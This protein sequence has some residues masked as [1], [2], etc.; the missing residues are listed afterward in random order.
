MS[1]ECLK[2]Y[3]GRLKDLPP[4][5]KALAPPPPEAPPTVPLPPGVYWHAQIGKYCVQL[6]RAGQP[7]HGPYS[8]DLNALHEWRCA[9]EAELDAQGVPATRVQAKKTPASRQS[10]TPGVT[11]NERMQR[12]VGKCVD[13][14]ASAEAGA[15]RYRRT[16]YSTDEAACVAALAALRAQ[17]H[18]AFETEVAKRQA[19]DPRLAGLD[20]APAFADAQR[21]T[22]YCRVDAQT[23]YVP[24]RVVAGAK[25]YERA[26]AECHQLAIP[27]T[28]GGLPTHCKQHGG[29]RRCPGPVG[30]TECP[31]GI[32]VDLGERD[33]YDGR[34]A[35]CFCAALPNDPRAA[36][37][38]SSVH[39]K[40]RKVTDELKKCFPEY[41]WV[42]DKTFAHR[43]FVVGTRHRPDARF[44]HHDRV[45]IVEVDE[46]SHRSYLCSKEREREASF[47]VQNRGKTVVMIRFNPD[48]YTDY[49]GKRIPSCFT[50]A[51]KDNQIVHVP[52]KQKA[53]WKRRLAELVRTIETLADPDF[54]LPPKQEDRPLLI[55][56]LF[57]DNVNATPEDERVAA[58]LAGRKAIGKRQRERDEP[59]KPAKPIQRKS[60]KPVQR[61]VFDDS[62]DSD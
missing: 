22:V 5:G 9:K 14:L 1:K 36:A 46:H 6:N 61:P 29:G 33:R 56:E 27:N 41:N 52:D 42:F 47:V 50:A 18:T 12:W 32:S 59:A 24:F 8:M 57:Y 11:W 3:E 4:P 15:P 31:H 30:A 2:E 21:G 26:C 10:S 43:T 38:R 25:R 20:R 51:T 16:P 58:G 54:E 19:A 60:I 48:A 45:V 34:C 23:K 37:A 7:Y 62:S 49:A 28:P 44:K 55:C 39:A 17:E 40:E 35:S 53:Q 13:R